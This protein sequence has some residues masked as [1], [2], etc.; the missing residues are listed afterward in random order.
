MIPARLCTA[1]RIDQVAESVISGCRESP[2]KV[3]V[4]SSIAQRYFMHEKW[5]KGKGAR[6]WTLDLVEIASIAPQIN[7]V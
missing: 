3:C 2:L 6:A 4:W 5:E 7:S 1:A